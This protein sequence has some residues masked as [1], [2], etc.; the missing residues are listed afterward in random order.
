MCLNW[1]KWITPVLNKPNITLK[2]IAG[3]SR[4][5]IY[6]LLIISIHL[7]LYFGRH[8]LSIFISFVGYSLLLFSKF[9]MLV[10]HLSFLSNADILSILVVHNHD[11]DLTKTTHCMWCQSP[12]ETTPSCHV[13]GYKS[14][15]LWMKVYLK[16]ESMWKKMKQK[17]K[18]KTK[19]SLPDHCKNLHQHFQNITLS[20]RWWEW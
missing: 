20:V 10:R 19:A 14:I 8:Y 16:N 1:I 12:A 15:T 3:S 4:E 18:T 2:W 17:K 6:C 13:E 9:Q 7:P 11:T 5:D